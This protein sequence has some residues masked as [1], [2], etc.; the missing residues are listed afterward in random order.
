MSNI[1]QI[2][3]ISKT[4]KEPEWLLGWREKQ[5]AHASTLPKAIKHGIGISALFPE[6]EPDFVGVAEYHVDTTKGLEIYTWG[7]AVTQEEIEPLLRGLLES[8]FFPAP[9][10][11]FR[12]TGNALF[13][14][15]L[16]VYV[17][18]N[19]ADDGTFITEKLTLDTMIP[20]GSSSDVIVVIVKEGAKFEFTSNVSGGALGSVHSRTLIVVTEQDTVTRITQRDVLSTGEMVMHSSRGI[21]AG[22]SGLVWRELLAGDALVSSITH[23]LLIG[24]SAKVKVL[25]ALVASNHAEFDVDVSA[26]H[27][28]D[29]THSDI[30]T[31]GTGKDKSK[32]LYRGLVVMKDGVHKVVGA[33]EAKFLVL[34]PGAKIDAIPSLDVASNDVSCAHKLS[35]SHVREGDMFYPKLRGLSDEESRTLFF[36][37][38]F[39]HVFSGE[40]NADIMNAISSINELQRPPLDRHPA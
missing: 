5:M 10:D 27:L 21:V 23:N 3:E 19:M 25:Q 20:K 34:T 4:L 36:E 16:V 1:T 37:G 28:A 38:H 2:K 24:S 31:A 13:S 29:D 14:S 9:K 33:Q 8:D 17:Q 40:E 6:T 7:E 11:F 26:E 30:F 39:A 18:P 32:I 22:N 15:G 12:A 35:I